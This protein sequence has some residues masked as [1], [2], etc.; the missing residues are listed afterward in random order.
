MSVKPLRVAVVGAGVIGLAVARSLAQAGA[1]VTV[2]EREFIGAGTSITTFAWVN[3]NGKNPSS[4]HALNCAGMN[5]H[6]ELQ[7]S[8]NA[9]AKWLEPMGTY[10][11]ATTPDGQEE[12]LARIDSLQKSNYPV[13]KLAREDMSSLPELK[14]PSEVDSVWSF[15]SEALV[16]PTILLAWLWSEAKAN[17]AELKTGTKVIALSEVSNGA[18]LTLSDSSRWNGDHVVLATGR[19]TPELSGLVG[20][21]VA[22]L[23]TQ[24]I[25]P[26]ACGFL[27]VTNRLSIQLRSN[28]ITPELN[29]RPDGGGLLL[30]QATD[31][32]DRADPLAPPTTDSVIAKELLTRLGR[33]FENTQNA[34]IEQISVGQRSRPADGLPVIG[35]LTEQK[36]VY[37]AASHSGITLGPLLG[38]LVAEELLTGQRSSLLA[39]YAPNRLVNQPVENFTPVSAR[40][41]PGEQ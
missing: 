25:D 23:D 16:H 18:T 34:K 15:P 10:E 5:E 29:V 3:S 31:L 17:G 32:D 20:A 37:V 9:Q 6:A 1:H 30:L 22:M 24:R 38:R 14:L 12:L 41:F 2:F 39:D 19:W 27:A 7:S 11:W 21:K 8:A 33:L 26:R 36:R 40:K 35:H 28:L 4:Y 13:L